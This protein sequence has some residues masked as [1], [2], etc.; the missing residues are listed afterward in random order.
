MGGSIRV[1]NH[2]VAA[3]EEEIDSFLAA[4]AIGKT[5]T[6]YTQQ[7]A[8]RRV[9]YFCVLTRIENHHAGT[10]KNEENYRRRTRQNTHEAQ[11]QI[12]GRITSQS[13]R[14]K[15]GKS[16]VMKRVPVKFTS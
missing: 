14:V 7:V 12:K 9:R 1:I 2:A 6:I 13:A 16:R 8:L 11:Y 15:I 4:R 3:R 10:A 5:A